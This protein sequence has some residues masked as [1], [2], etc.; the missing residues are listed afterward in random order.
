MKALRKI[1]VLVGA[2]LLAT[3]SVA[4]AADPPVE[5]RRNPFERPVMEA[6][7]SA[8]PA[9][10]GAKSVEKPALRAVLH[11]GQKSVVNFGGVI[12]QI[13]ESSNGYELVAVDE[14]AATFRNNGKII[15]FSFYEQDKGSEL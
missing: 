13:G 12:M 1:S 6:A 5:L 8:Q 9:S 3:V 15:V 14:G 2:T 10:G 7:E 11:A 4:G